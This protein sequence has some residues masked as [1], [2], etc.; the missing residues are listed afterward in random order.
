[1]AFGRNSGVR[2]L[3]AEGNAYAS[4]AQAAGPPISNDGAAA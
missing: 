3:K 2:R 4:R 1:M